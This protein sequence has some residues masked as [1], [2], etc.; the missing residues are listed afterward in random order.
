MQFRLFSLNAKCDRSDHS[1]GGLVGQV[2]AL[3]LNV[4][5]GELMAWFSAVPE[6]SR[7]EILAQVLVGVH[8]TT[9]VVWA[10]IARLRRKFLRPGTCSCSWMMNSGTMLSP[11]KRRKRYLSTHSWAA[12]D[13]AT[14]PSPWPP[15]ETSEC[16]SGAC[17]DSLVSVACCRRDTYRWRNRPVLL[18]SASQRPCPRPT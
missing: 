3:K 9:A 11:Y 1:V 8:A 13:S 10:R 7:T 15:P 2:R 6:P 5:N 12:S 4:D 18:A 14:N 16:E 17:A